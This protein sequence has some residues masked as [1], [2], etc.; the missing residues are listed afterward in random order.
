[1]LA[2]IQ[3]RMTSTRLPGKVLL[4]VAGKPMIQWV[5]DRLR[6][7]GSLTN[8]VVATSGESSDDLICDYCNR[9]NISHYRGALHDV[10]GRFLRCAESENAEAFLRVSGDSPLIDPMLVD[11]AVALYMS[12]SCDLATNVQVRSFPKGQSVE[13]IRTEAL[14]GAYPYFA[15]TSDFEH[16]TRYFYLHPE[17]V[18]IESF[19]SRDPMGSVQLSVDTIEDLQAVELILQREGGCVSWKSAARLKREILI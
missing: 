10:A 17:Q 3:A 9:Q 18:S 14:A 1:M 7:A 5:V 6:Q 13:V 8:I 19:S 11:R 12:T 15:D 4:P 16:V 2:I